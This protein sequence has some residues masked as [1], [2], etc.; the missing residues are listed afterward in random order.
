MTTI[1]GLCLPDPPRPAGRRRPGDPSP[2]TT[3]NMS[4]DIQLIDPIT[5]KTLHSQVPHDRRGGT[6]EMGGTTML[7]LN[8]TYNYSKHFYRVFG[9]DGIRTI[10][11]M[12]GSASI[13]V[14][15]AAIAQLDD[16][17]SD[18]YWVATE[19][20]AKRALLN[21]LDLALMGPDGVWS[22]D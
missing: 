7:W 9:D 13:P 10:Y 12:T 1:C 2:T 20:N 17:I 16:N 11:G 22:G 15:M 5:K 21:L 18:D 8:I 14:I 4:Y 3:V 19:G 6:Y